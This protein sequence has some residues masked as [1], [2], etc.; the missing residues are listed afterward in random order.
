MYFRNPFTWKKSP[1]IKSCLFF[2][3]KKKVSET[4]LGVICPDVVH[5]LAFIKGTRLL[6]HYHFFICRYWLVCTYLDAFLLCNIEPIILKQQTLIL[7]DEV[8]IAFLS[9]ETVFWMYTG[10]CSESVK[11]LLWNILEGTHM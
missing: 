4:L 2:F 9:Q 8:S 5:A 1:G 10:C 7:S 11:L 6:N 3:L